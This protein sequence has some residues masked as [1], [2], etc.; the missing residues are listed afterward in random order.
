MTVSEAGG[1]HT[2]FG[3][4]E[5]KEDGKTLCYATNTVFLIKS[6]MVLRR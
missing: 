3:K 1:S 5:Y 2:D 4:G 6:T